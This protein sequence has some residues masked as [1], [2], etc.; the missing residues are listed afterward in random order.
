MKQIKAVISLFILALYII[1]ISV[2]I[3]CHAKGIKD[4]E[5]TIKSFILVISIISIALA[6]ER[7]P[8]EHESVFAKF[9]GTDRWD[10][11]LW[12]ARSEEVLVC[13]EYDDGSRSVTTS[14]T[15]DGKWHIARRRVLHDF[16]VIAWM[17]LPKP[18]KEEEK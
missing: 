13:I 18:M 1:A 4:L 2:I 17:P 8:E 14:F 11:N 5:E 6:V 9:Y 16:K 10:N 15:L 3:L 7:L 12:R